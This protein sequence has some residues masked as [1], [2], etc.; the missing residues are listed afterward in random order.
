MCKLNDTLLTNQ[1]VKEKIKRDI[2]KY[3]ETV[4]NGNTTYRNLRNAE[5][6]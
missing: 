4:K 3:L 5:Q 6:F 2:K 1:Q